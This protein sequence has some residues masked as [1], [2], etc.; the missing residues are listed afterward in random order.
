MT[1]IGGRPDANWSSLVAL[2]RDL[3]RHPELAHQEGVTAQLL[4]DVLKRHGADQVV[5]DIAG[6]GLAA[7]FHGVSSGSTLLVRC[8][9]DGLP[10][11]ERSGVEWA[12]RN[13]GRAHACGHDGHMAMVTGLAMELERRRPERGSVVLLYQPA[14][15]VGEGARRVLDDPAFESLRPDRVFA[16]HNLPG[17]E[18]GEVV[19]RAGPLASASRGLVATLDGKTSHAGEPELGQSPALALARAIAGLANGTFLFCLP[20]SSGACRTGW[21]GILQQQL[22]HRTRPCNFAQLI[23]RLLEK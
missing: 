5:T 15:E 9:L 22:D 17:F 2:R 8:E 4:V 12:S 14:E 20:G 11:A 13:A 3:H 6:H 19:L 10:I 18:L 21:T 1:T 16:L 7:V 23:P